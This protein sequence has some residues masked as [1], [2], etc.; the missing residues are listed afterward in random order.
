[1]FS[2]YHEHYTFIIYYSLGTKVEIKFEIN[3][4]I[5]CFLQVIFVE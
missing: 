2:C 1:M 4:L 3:K 5:A